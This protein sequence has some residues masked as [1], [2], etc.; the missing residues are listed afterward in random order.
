MQ[1][2]GNTRV[3]ADASDS[4]INQS[5]LQ[6]LLTQFYVNRDLLLKTMQEHPQNLEALTASLYE[7]ISPRKEVS[8]TRADTDTYDQYFYNLIAM[9]CLYTA[10]G[11]IRLAIENAANLTALAARK[12][13]SSTKNLRQLPGNLPPV[14]YLNRF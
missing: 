4:S 2:Y 12:T 11:G 7:T 14:F 13:V 1:R 9:A 6:V 5:I 10:L 8:L 3:N